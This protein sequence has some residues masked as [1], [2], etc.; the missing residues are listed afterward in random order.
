MRVTVIDG[1]SDIF[2]A[3]TMATGQIEALDLQ[4]TVR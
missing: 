1:T 2:L 4:L 3:F